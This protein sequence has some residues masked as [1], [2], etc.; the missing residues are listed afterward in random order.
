MSKE[1]EGDVEGGGGE[2]LHERMDYA[3][4]KS[5]VTED[6]NRRLVGETKHRHYGTHKL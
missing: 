1:S 3:G 6:A 5:Y 4:A 2:F